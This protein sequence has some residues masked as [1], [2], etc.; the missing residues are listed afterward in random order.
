MKQ[1]ERRQQTIRRLMATTK[2]LIMEKG[3]QSMTMQDIVNR[4]GM[5]KGAIFHYVKNKN[6]IFI[7]VLQERLEETNE[8]FM[9]E[10]EQGSPNFDDP[11]EKIRESIIAYENPNDVTN[12]VLLYL[13]GKEEDPLVAQALKNYYDR[14]AYLSKLWIETGQR[15]G[16]IPDTVESEKTGDMFTLITFGLRVRSGIPQAQA[17]FKAQDLSEF[18]RD[19]LSWQVR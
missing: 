10:V 8:R 6:E 12:K 11:M 9:K 1:E 17:A 3:C 13:L 5:S 19:R 2:E 4:S 15:H 18:I 16:V 7:W 14:S